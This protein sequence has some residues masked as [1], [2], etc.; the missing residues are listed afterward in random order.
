[1][2]V[3][4]GIEKKTKK[5]EDED[6]KH[7]DRQ[8]LGHTIFSYQTHCVTCNSP[9]VELSE[10]KMFVLVSDIFRHPPAIRVRTSIRQLS[11]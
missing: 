11:N 1:M 2:C 9:H 8:S 5:R 4:E 7:R 10:I 6:G 3:K